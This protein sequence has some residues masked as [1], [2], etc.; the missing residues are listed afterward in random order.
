[1]VTEGLSQA[2]KPPPIA[3]AYPL[4]YAE[5]DDLSIEYPS[6]DGEPMAD[7]QLQ[8]YHMTNIK[9][10]LDS[11]YENRPDMFV[12]GDLLVYY[13]MNDNETRVAPDVFVVR[14]VP[15]R[16]LFRDSWIVWREGKPPEFAL[17][18]ATPRTWRRDAT[19]KREIYAG[20][21]VLEYWRFDPTGR[22]FAPV[23]IGETLIDGAYQPLP[24]A[25]NGDGILRGHSA[26]LG[27]ELCVQPG[28]E[29]RL[30]DPASGQWL[31][32]IREESAG[33]RA[34]EAALQ[35]AQADLHSVESAL[36]QEAAARRAAEEE[37]QRLREQ[38][39]AQQSES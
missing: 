4:D 24:V 31:R 5:E 33:R 15:D 30:Y 29:L 23:L 8:Y 25:D 18:V 19:E 9:A 11:W 16:D 14:G 17:E 10:G 2:V 22:F 38:L 37:L 1:M 27:L 6:S 34:A 26:V 20:M 35:T 32:T 3:P 13:R 39:R 21:G 36:Q 12:A 28:L 7:N